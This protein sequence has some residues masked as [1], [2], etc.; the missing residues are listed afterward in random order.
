[1]CATAECGKRFCRLLPFALLSLEHHCVGMVTGQ[2][3]CEAK[4]LLCDINPSHL[5]LLYLFHPTRESELVNN[6]IG[7]TTLEASTLFDLIVDGGFTSGFVGLHGGSW[8]AVEHVYGN[9]GG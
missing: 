7:N 3:T 9:D 5:S 1:M 6:S 2:R 4:R 8:T